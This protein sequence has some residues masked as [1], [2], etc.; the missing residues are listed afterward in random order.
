MRSVWDLILKALLRIHGYAQGN[1]ERKF[2]L[3]VSTVWLA[4]LL[5]KFCGFFFLNC[6]DI[7][8]YM[9]RVQDLLL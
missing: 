5:C 2:A 4:S 9:C 6:S 7:F 3:L 1:L 8:L